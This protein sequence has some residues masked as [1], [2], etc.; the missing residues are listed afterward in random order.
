MRAGENSAVQSV[1][2]AAADFLK[3]N[4]PPEGIETGWAGLSYVNVVWQD[5]MVRGMGRALLGSFVTVFLMMVLLFRSPLWGLVS[6]LPLT[7]TILFIYGMLGW[8]GRDYDMPVAVLSSL[9]LGL[10]IDFAIHFIQRSRQI[11]RETGSFEETMTRTFGGTGRAI[12]RNM[13]VLAIGFVP[14]F[15]ASLTP[16]VT[17]GL[18]FFLIMVVSGVVT[19]LLLPAIAALRPEIFYTSNAGGRK[20]ARGL[21][22]TT[23]AALAIAA[24]ALGRPAAAG[25][26]DATAIMKQAHMNLYY[27]GDDGRAEVHMSLADKKGRERVREFTM[28]RW[29]A[30]D[31]GEQRYYTYFHEPADVRRTTFMVVKH[32]G[33]DDDRWIYVPAVDLVRRISANDKNSSFVG[34]DFSY[35][36]VSGR[37]WED[38]THELVREDEI[39]GA[40]VHVVKSVPV[41]GAK[42]AHRLSFVDKER[43]LPLREEYYDEKGGLLRVF[44]ADRVE[45]IGGHPTVTVRTMEDRKREHRTTVT[46]TAVEYDV[47]IEADL[48]AERYLKNPPREFIQ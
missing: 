35:E 48:F 36:D 3:G 11:H 34:S 20:M 28:L 4:P 7:G 21:A 38:D 46:F 27:A 40:A 25:E 10:S 14:M 44:T 42:W 22:T 30:E 32:V 12:F 19:M 37:H 2:D 26:T 1:V 9:T 13:M 5:R 24:A 43:L 39:D 18:F 6:M 41:D 33:K 45:V 8:T 23:L 47:G 29:D 31:G 15:F 16:Y 17:V